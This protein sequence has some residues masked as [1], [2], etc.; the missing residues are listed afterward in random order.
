MMSNFS[1]R[2][3]TAYNMK[4]DGYD[5][6]S[7]GQFTNRVH[8]LLLPMLEWQEN[9]RILDVACGTGTF[10]AA[11]NACKPIAGFGVDIAER[12]IKMAAAK[13]P[14]MEFR[15]SGCDRIPFADG[16]MDIVT[17]CAAYHHFP[18]VAA[19]AKEAD[20]ILKPGGMLY[21][22]DMFVP[23]LVRIVVNPFVP[24]LFKDGDVR[25]YSPKQITA[26]FKRHGFD[27]IDT[28]TSGSVQIVS[29]QKVSDGSKNLFIG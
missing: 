8:H 19:F 27:E 28:K 5:H 26:N 6:S 23:P 2:S 29:M 18:D 7:E 3:K 14:G 24:L 15:V 12:M 10:L 25:F 22:A 20:R 9:Q 11:V 1:E 21:I 13:N 4:A 17:V 16:S